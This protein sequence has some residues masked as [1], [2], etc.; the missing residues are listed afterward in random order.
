MLRIWKLTLWKVS[1]VNDTP[2]HIPLGRS[3]STKE[4]WE[5]ETRRLIPRDP[6]LVNATNNLNVLIF[7]LH[8]RL[9]ASLRLAHTTYFIWSLWPSHRT[10]LASLSGNFL[11]GD[12]KKGRG[13]SGSNNWLSVRLGRTNVFKQD[14]A[15]F[16]HNSEIRSK[17]AANRLLHAGSIISFMNFNFLNFLLWPICLPAMTL[18]WWY[19]QRYIE[20]RNSKFL[21]FIFHSLVCLQ[22]I[23]FRYTA[24]YS[25]SAIRMLSPELQSISHLATLA[26]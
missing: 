24:N 18:S 14:E 5:R 2:G 19:F 25:T 6:N 11:F 26:D 3:L 12:N 21:F 1:G 17:S 7:V 23:N 22:I 9:P 20:E 16:W 13:N 8:I 10:L 15:L 4:F